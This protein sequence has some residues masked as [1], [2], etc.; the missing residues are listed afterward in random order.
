MNATKNK[1]DGVTLKI[2]SSAKYVSPLG[3]AINALCL[4]A[5]GSESCAQAVQLAVVE[6]V[7]NVIIHAY[8]NQADND[9]IVQWHQENRHLYVEIVDYG[10]SLTSLPEAILPA[11][12]AESGRGWWII[13]S[14]VDEYYYKV[15]ECIERERIYKPEMDS[16]YSED[17]VIKSHCNILTFIKKF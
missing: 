15:V 16:E 11:F 8:N 13:N 6:A 17:K 1:P 9:I 5:S 3:E 2:T 12:D 10:L 7:N 4:Y 14:C